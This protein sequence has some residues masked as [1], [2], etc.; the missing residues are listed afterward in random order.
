[1]IMNCRVFS[2]MV[3]LGFLGGAADCMA[4]VFWRV[5]VKVFTDSGGNRPADRSNS[6]IQDDYVYYNALLTKY[7]RGTRFSLTEIVQLPSSLSGWYNVAA[8]NGSNRDMLLANATSNATLYAYRTDNVNVYINNSSSGVCC[9]AGNGL[10]FT[11]NEDD[12]ITPVHEIGHM[13]GLSHTQGS[14]CNSCCPDPLGYCDTPGSDGIADTILDLPCWSR[15]QVAQNNFGNT[16]ANLTASQR[17]QVDDVWLNIMSYH[18][19]SFNNGLERLT[20]GQMDQVAVT[21]NGTRD[22]VTGNY[23][24][25]VDPTS[26]FDGL[27]GGLNATTAFRSIDGAVIGSGND[28][29]LLIRSGTYNK[30][31]AGTW[32]IT[33]NRVLTSRNGT[34]RLTRT[35]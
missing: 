7:A 20:P 2:V 23:F 15:D 1:M 25:F 29:V 18:Y 11:G 9:G 16:Y 19:G 27:G 8:R 26:L 35:P 17:D 13:L 33:A 30:P 24:R 3:A 21:S 14:G 32:R 10:I 34:V 4:Q 6:E 5:S 22:A 28:D 12:H 31:T